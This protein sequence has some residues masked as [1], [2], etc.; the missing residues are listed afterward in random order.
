MLLDKTKFN[1]S[2]HLYM[3]R[4]I[5]DGSPSGFSRITSSEPTKAKSI[6]KNF[7]LIGL[8]FSDKVNIQDYGKKPSFIEKWQ[9]LAHPDMI[10]TPENNSLLAECTKFD[11]KAILV[12]PTSSIRTVK[13]LD[14]DGWFLKLH[15][16]G[17]IGRIIRKLERKHAISA[18]EVSNII[19]KAIDTRKLPDKFFMQREPFARIIDL[20]D[21]EHKI[22]EWGIV[23]RESF[24]YPFNDKIELLIPAFS[25]FSK[26]PRNTNHKSILTQLIEKQTICVEDFLFEDLVAPVFENY[27]ELLLN[28]GLQLECHAQNTLFAIDK[29]FR[30]LGI[31]AR[32]MESIDRDISLMANFNIRQSIEM[33]DYKCLKKSDYNYQIMHSFMFDNKLGEYLI[34]PIINDVSKNFPNFNVKSFFAK[35]KEY[36][37]NFIAKLPDNF[38]PAN[39][40]WYGDKKEIRDRTKR[41]EYVEN[42]NPKFR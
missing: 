41:K 12:S 35:I 23:L 7:H 16:D 33:L 36:N 37:H 9:M 39:N 40:K 14:K 38:F 25:L 19:E 29:N 2:G 18:V 13:A 4:Y 8:S 30:V 15:Y 20:L 11:L 10:Y 22:Y 6:N 21:K 28:C 42:N 34:S 27:F 31:V 3:E 26:D 24:S 17:L 5:N 32:D 1:L